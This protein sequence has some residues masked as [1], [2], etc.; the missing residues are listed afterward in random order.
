MSAIGTV[1][2][3]AIAIAGAV[4]GVKIAIR[5]FRSLVGG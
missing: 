3:V 2:P 5:A 1:A 4:I